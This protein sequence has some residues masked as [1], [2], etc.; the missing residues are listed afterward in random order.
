VQLNIPDM[1]ST[2]AIGLISTKMPDG[3]EGFSLL[4]IICLEFN[5]GLQLGMGFT[6]N[7]LGGLVGLNRTMMLDALVMGVRTGTLN[8]ILFPQ[9]VII[10][11][12][13]RI[14]SDL[15]A[16]FPP[17]NDIFLIGPMAKLGWGSPTLISVSFGIVIEIPGNTAILGVLRLTL[18]TADAPLI[19]LQVAFIGA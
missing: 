1:V 2:T 13:A 7:G 6:L 18:P 11:N 16:I 9:G 12:A 10:A 17:R 4:V 15:R 19:L 3:S 14:I 8:S 5:P